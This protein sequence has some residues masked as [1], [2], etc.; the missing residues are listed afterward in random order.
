MTSRRGLYF[1]PAGIAVIVGI[2]I[3]LAV[4]SATATAPPDLGPFAG[5]AVVAPHFKS[6]EGSWE[7]PRVLG[8][9]GVG[10]AST[11]L[12]AQNYDAGHPAFVQIGTTDVES[13]SASAPI[14]YFAFWSD[15]ARGYHPVRLFAVQPGDAMVARLIVRKGVSLM[16]RD[17]TRH[18]TRTVDVR[19]ISAA[20]LL[21]VE[22]FQEDPTLGT[23]PTSGRHAPYTQTVPV[24]FTHLLVNGTVPRGSSLL[25]Q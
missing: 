21:G 20:A 13:P 18:R 15:P 9:R 14:G 11:W 16:V 22:W 17:V 2:A 23:T 7:V 25:S 5:Y 3:F 24:R 10:T 1:V 19:D 4:R 8:R 6:A 12:G